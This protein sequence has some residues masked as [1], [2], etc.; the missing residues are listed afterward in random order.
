MS[1]QL[2]YS[3]QAHFYLRIPKSVLCQNHLIKSW[4]DRKFN[5]TIVNLGSKHNK[6]HFFIFQNQFSI[7]CI[8][9]FKWKGAIAFYSYCLHT[10]RQIVVQFA[11]SDNRTEN[12]SLQLAN[13]LNKYSFD[14]SATGGGPGFFQISI[15]RRPFLVYYTAS[16]VKHYQLCI[17]HRVV[18]TS[19]KRKSDKSCHVCGNGMEGEPVKKKSGSRGKEINKQERKQKKIK[20]FIPHSPIYR[21]YNDIYSIWQSTNQSYHLLGDI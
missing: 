20:S 9:C 10:Y 6:T 13:S 16:L 15:N 3:T 19:S 8:Q 2:L 12:I 11:E 5:E 7:G 18:K 17:C 21:S 4:K 14:V 1:V